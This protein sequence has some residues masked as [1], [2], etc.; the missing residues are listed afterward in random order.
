ML[1]GDV[2]VA[3]VEGGLRI[4]GDS[5]ANEI[6]VTALGS[7]QYEVAGQNGTTINGQ[8]GPIT[9]TGVSSYIKVHL[10]GG[11]DVATI[12]GDGSQ[13]AKKVS[14][15][16]GAGNDVITLDGI[17]A[18]ELKVETGAG[19]DTVNIIDL[20]V[21]EAEIETGADDD[22]VSLGDPA[23]GTDTLIKAKKLEIETGGGNDAIRLQDAVLQAIVC[24]L[25]TGRGDDSV[26]LSGIQVEG[27]LKVETGAGTDQ[28]D[29]N[30]AAL[31]RLLVELGSG[32]NDRASLTNTTGNFAKLDGGSGAGDSLVQT[33]ST[34]TITKVKGFESVV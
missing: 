8:A 20:D 29:A 14:V 32:D 33:A 23:S 13:L 5:Q 6:A 28:V 15:E 22:V 1:A 17:G 34:F 2:T 21:V 3:V 31:D 27:T 11:D 7:G 4:G 26:L 10:R 12:A 30:D 16:S 24:E 25:E 9:V 18:K 19:T